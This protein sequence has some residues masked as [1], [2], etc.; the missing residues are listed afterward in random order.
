MNNPFDAGCY[1]DGT[2]GHQHTR[3]RCADMINSVARY[4]GHPGERTTGQELV[5]ELLGEMSDDASEEYDACEW[6]NEHAPREGHSWDWQ[7]GD[8]GLWPT[9]EE[10][11]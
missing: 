8:F 4:L 2:F 9:D 1:G 5:A 10:E 7:E 6:L 11:V 3:E